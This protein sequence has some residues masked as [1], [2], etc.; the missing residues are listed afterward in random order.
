M[1]VTEQMMLYAEQFQQRSEYLEALVKD[2]HRETY[3]LL[4][5]ILEIVERIEYNNRAEVINDNR[6]NETFK[7]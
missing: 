6:E 7:D 2:Q 1:S 5:K 4:L 3:D